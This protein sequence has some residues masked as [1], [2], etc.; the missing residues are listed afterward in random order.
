MD[1]SL[2][3]HCD[4][5]IIWG[6]FAGLSALLQVRK[7]M[8]SEVSIKLFDKNEQFLYVP[9]LHEAVLDDEKLDSLQFSFAEYYPNE[10]VQGEVTSARDG[11]VS[12]A[13]WTQRTCKYLVISPW[14]HTFMPAGA[15]SSKIVHTVRYAS[16]IK[17]L[18]AALRSAHNVLVIGGGY[19]GVEVAAMIVGKSKHTPT[20]QTITLIHSRDRVTHTMSEKVSHRAQRR[21]REHWIILHLGQRVKHIDDDHVELNDWTKLDADCVIVCTGN[22]LQDGLIKNASSPTVFLAGDYEHTGLEATAHNAMIEWR[23]VGDQIADHMYGISTDY[24][25]LFS[26]TALAMALGP[27]D[28]IMTD[29]PHGIFLPKLVW[30]SKWIIEKRVIWE[31]KLKILFWI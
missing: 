12:L 11:L 7:R 22:T 3:L 27:Y 17:P 23:R 8:G 9:G 26:R 21:M 29:G 13:N 5:A 6:W 30:L 10:F 14:A 16:D 28:G 20:N 31:F 18:N 1:A 24:P 25:P 19:T 15:E 4:V 2:S